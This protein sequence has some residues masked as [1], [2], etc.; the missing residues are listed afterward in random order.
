MSL[1]LKLTPS[2]LQKPET[3]ITHLISITRIEGDLLWG[4]VRATNRCSNSKSLSVSRVKLNFN[5]GL[6]IVD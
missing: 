2:M 3:A 5:S 6:R 4:K 1:H